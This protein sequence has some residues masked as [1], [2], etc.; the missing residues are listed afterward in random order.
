MIMKSEIEDLK[1]KQLELIKDKNREIDDHAE[2]RKELF[3][4]S[5]KLLRKEKEYAVMDKKNVRLSQENRGL[6][7]SRDRLKE[8]NLNLEVENGGLLKERDL[9]KNEA[10]RFEE[11]YD[12]LN[13]A[14]KEKKDELTRTLTQL[15]DAKADKAKAV[16]DSINAEEDRSRAAVEVV[17]LS[18]KLIAVHNQLSESIS[19]RGENSSQVVK[20]L[21]ENTEL[22]AKVKKLVE[23]IRDLKRKVGKP[24]RVVL[25]T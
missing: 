8:L 25:K 12:K 4:A 7:D 17:Q 15:H 19:Q 20:A 18:E 13:V 16:Q 14:H 5:D 3:E 24:P 6:K 22:K 10:K 2:T 11:S 1:A 9:Y 23:E 21:K